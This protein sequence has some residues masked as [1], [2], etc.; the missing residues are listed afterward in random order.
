MV[1]VDEGDSA[2]TAGLALASA[3]L[4]PMVWL[5]APG[6]INQVM[7]G[8]QA[9]AFCRTLESALDALGLGWSGLGDEVDAVT[10]CQ[11]APARV[12]DARAGVVALTARVGRLGS[13]D[14]TAPRWAWCGH[15]FGSSARSAAD[16]MASIFLGCPSAWL[17]DAY[18]PSEPWSRYAMAPAGAIYEQLGLGVWVSPADGG[19]LAQWQA[20]AAEPIDAGLVAVN[21]KGRA[22]EFYL[23]PGRACGRDVPMLARPAA[24]YVI[25]SFSAQRPG[26]DSSV[27]GAWRSRGVF[28]YIGS[29][30]EPGL[31]SFVPQRTFAARL[32][33]LFP[34]GAAGRE[35]GLLENRKLAVLGDPLWMLQAGPRRR[36]DGPLP[37][38][39]VR[40]LDELAEQAIGRG[41]LGEGAWLLRMAG[42]DE[43]LVALAMETLGE[44]PRRVDG[45]LALASLGALFEAQRRPAVAAMFARLDPGDKAQAWVEDLAWHALR[46]LLGEAASSV[47][48]ARLLSGH[49]RGPCLVADAQAVAD[50]LARAGQAGEALTVLR[51]VMGRARHDAERAALAEAIERLR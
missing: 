5:D 28:A 4:Q 9:D 47:T 6:G 13:I 32:G 37:L 34:F 8:E 42:R 17:F 10:L 49:L 30:D 35:D 27:A 2:W 40:A 50:A 36:A 21:T 39:G 19:G 7:A 14:R 3:R 23:R 15:V 29:V 12:D 1:V 25:H 24:A 33:S 43:A 22:N 44:S 51:A 45:G 46:P 18:P 38:E 20:Q 26:V 11:N 48:I 16:A 41:A 31:Q